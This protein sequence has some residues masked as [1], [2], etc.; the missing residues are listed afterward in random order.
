VV[1]DRLSKIIPDGVYLANVANQSAASGNIDLV[2][3]LKSSDNTPGQIIETLSNFK[4]D[5]IF[6]NCYLPAASYAEE[7]LTDLMQRS[8]ITWNIGGPDAPGNIVAQQF[9][10]QIHSR[11]E[12]PLPGINLPAQVDDLSYF[13]SLGLEANT[14]G[15]P[16]AGEPPAGVVVEEV[17]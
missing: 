13:D 15:Q 10:F 4:Q 7:S 5:S 12:R 8:G 9:D 3:S 17:N 6:A 11:L 1:L 2:V 14:L 16:T